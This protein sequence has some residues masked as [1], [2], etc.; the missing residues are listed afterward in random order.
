MDLFLGALLQHN[1]LRG[2]NKFLV[3]ND[4][5]GRTGCAPAFLINTNCTNLI[6]LHELDPETELDAL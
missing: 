1:I 3:Y 6:E 5:R 2:L 4:W